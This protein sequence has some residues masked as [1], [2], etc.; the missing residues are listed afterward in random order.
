MPLEPPSPRTSRSP[1]WAVVQLSPGLPLTGPMQPWG[2]LGA[3]S[4]LLAHS[5]WEEPPS[6]Q[7]PLRV[8]PGP[9]VPSGPVHGGWSREPSAS[10]LFQARW[11][12]RP[13]GAASL[14]LTLG[15]P[16]NPRS[17]GHNPPKDKVPGC[18]LP[19][20]EGQ[21][22][23]KRP[24]AEVQLKTHALLLSFEKPN[25]PSAAD[26]EK[27]GR[28]PIRTWHKMPEHRVC[29]Q[30]TAAARGQAEP[31]LCP[32]PREVS[33]GTRGPPPSPSPS[34]Q[35]PPPRYARPHPPPATLF[36]CPGTLCR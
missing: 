24:C 10:S 36:P 6:R 2:R 17:P 19:L 12:P 35:P 11:F 7:S 8:S 23:P 32:G 3:A 25:N 14:A 22:G 27:H 13:L 4:P 1:P 26:C 30:S 31:G 20:S 18:S 33:P 34:A 16:G 21:V 15:T 5:C 29:A 9:P 28:S